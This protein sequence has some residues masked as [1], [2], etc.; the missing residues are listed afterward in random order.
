M[1]QPPGCCSVVELRQYTLRAGQRDALI[2]LFD[3]EFVE[4]QEAVGIHVIGQFR[5]LDAPDRFVWM[6][7]FTDMHSRLQGLAAFYGGPVWAEHRSAANATMIDVDDVLL[8]RP[9]HDGSGLPH[10]P[11]VRPGAAADNAS[12]RAVLIEVSVYSVVGAE[13]LNAE[14]AASFAAVFGER[15][16]PMLGRLGAPPI[17]WFVTEDA[18]NTYPALPIRTGE[19]V[20]VSLARFTDADDH[21]NYVHRRDA[22]PAWAHELEAMTTRLSRPVQRLR[23]EPTSRS[24]LR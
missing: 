13:E 24:G 17:A 11:P 14:K 16:A 21:A 7:G 4:T 22:D 20:L 12:Q 10:P 19:S 6:R 23:L 15:I 8:L 2:T 18:E 3:R 9:A 5:D 1:V